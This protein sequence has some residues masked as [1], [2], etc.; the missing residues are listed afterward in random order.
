LIGFIRLLLAGFSLLFISP[1]YASLE[2]PT[3]YF[4]GLSYAGSSANINQRF[5]Y[6]SKFS[7]AAHAGALREALKIAAPKNYDL[8]LEA[9]Q[10]SG[11][12][13]VVMMSLV[14]S[15]EIVSVAKIGRHY[16]LYTQI[17]GQA[18]FFDVKAMR[19]LKS[20]PIGFS[21]LDSKDREPTSTDKETNIDKVF[22]GVPGKPGLI[23][24]FATVAA[25]AEFSQLN[26]AFLQVSNVTIDET[27]KAGIPTAVREGGLAAE[28]VA[29]MFA[30]SITKQLGIPILPYKKN[31]T[32]DRMQMRL[33][34]GA[35]YSLEI[36]KPDY[37][38]NLDV[39]ALRKIQDKETDAAILYVYG[40]IANI[41]L[42]F[43]AMGR[44][45]LS[46]KFRYGKAV[47]MPKTELE[48]DDTTSFSESLQG[49]FD[50]IGTALKDENINLDWA[51][52][53]SLALPNAPPI[54]NQLKLS[55]ETL[56]KCK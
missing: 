46:A 51:K 50:N 14:I 34:D 12:D 56:R 44:D 40:S 27:A 2:R 37:F 28:W 47:V 25:T 17:R 32:T 54:Q 49:L 16:K 18:L 13:Q 35:M 30:E 21:Y 20:Y 36:P 55:A 6:A 26:N 9:P 15:N 33:A 3:V 24:R 42:N 5:P 41:V 43:P 52:Q 38:F 22:L 7:S 45:Y 11:N 48:L 4:A 19:V 31:D 8:S 23:E 29:D 1:S 10:I 39:L 53:N